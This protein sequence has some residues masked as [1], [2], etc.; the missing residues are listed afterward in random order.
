MS[1]QASEVHPLLA[2][3]IPFIPA[4][5][6]EAAVGC[7][8]TIVLQGEESGGG[9]LINREKKL[10][11]TQMHVVVPKVWRKG[12]RV[13]LPK[14][15]SMF[16]RI[17]HPRTLE[18]MSI[19]IEHVYYFDGDLALVR[20]SN[21]PSWMSPASIAP[22]SAFEAL[23]GKDIYSVSYGVDT[24][25]DKKLLFR[26]PSRG[27]ILDIPLVLD[28]GSR[29]S[30]MHYAYTNAQVEPGSSGLPYFDETGSVVGVA[31]AMN[32]HYT[33][34]SLTARVPSM[35]LLNNEIAPLGHFKV[36]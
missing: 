5:I 22:S 8:G 3:D 17:L 34:V 26:L 11:L 36:K 15:L 16:F 7:Q 23:V 31:H 25:Y 29:E 33:L 21:V 12:G 2:R 6:R 14:P 4:P 28:P 19:P 30:E 1:V 10:V 27:I 13:V 9:C 20:I 18:Q 24:L 32:G 35:M